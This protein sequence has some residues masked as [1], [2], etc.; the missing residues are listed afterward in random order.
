M[1]M[2]VFYIEN[3]SQE[4]NVMST[5]ILYHAFNLKGIQ[6][7]SADFFGSQIIFSATVGKHVTKCPDCGCL[8]SVRKG[9]K[10]RCFNMGPIGRKQAQLKLQTHRLKCTQCNKIW[11]PRLSF[12]EGKHRYTRS[13]SLTALD[14]LRFGTIKDVANY[15]HVGWDLI[16]E[17]HKTKLQRLYRKMPIHKIKYLGIDEFSLRKGH[18]Y[19][20]IFIDIQSGRIIH[21]VEGTSKDAVKPFL[22]LLAQKAKKLKAVAMD[23]SRSYS[24][25]VTKYLPKSKI[26]FDRYHI[27]AL[28]NKAI[29]TL[30]REQYGSLDDAGKK[31]LK[32][33][34]YLLLRNYETLHE[35]Y[36]EKLGE[37][38]KVN[39][40]LFIIHSMKEQFRLLW[41]QSNHQKAFNFF[42]Q[43]CL[44]AYT[45]DI[46]PLIKVALTLTKHR[47]GILN[48]FSHSITSGSVEGTNNKIKTLKRQAYGFRD[49]E[50]FKL[51][52]YH[53][54]CQGY[55]LTG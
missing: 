46:K 54:H 18:N 11:W 20:T 5:S 41:D 3:N 45:S 53:L 55:S 27:M 25:A 43:W 28:I 24:S 39:K 15:L 4:V 34:R 13:F 42:N 30:R 7:E 6:F 14:L 21:A 40:P 17:I 35:K 36:R 9:H 10:I 8:W 12:M 1:T 16:K 52:L 31:V 44:D 33:N 29:D 19:M 22:M 23:M 26:V 51:R 48:Y 49:I 37:L 50:Y 47:E 38:L 2:V 32:G